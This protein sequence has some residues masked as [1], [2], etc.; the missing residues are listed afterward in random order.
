[1]FFPVIRY[2]YESWTTKKAEHQRTD[3]CELW[4]WRRIFL[5]NWCKEPTHWK[6]PWCL[7]KLRARGEGGDTGWEVGWHHWLNGHK[8]EQSLGDGEGQGSLSC[9]SPCMHAK[10][11]QLCL[12][13]CN[14]MD[15]NP[16][17]PWNSPGK[18]TGVGCLALFHVV[19][20]SQTWLSDW[21]TTTIQKGMWARELQKEGESEMRPTYL[22]NAAQQH[23]KESLGQRPPKAAVVR[24][25]YS[26]SFYLICG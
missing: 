21:T 2:R 3:V 14:P 25:L 9:Y 8:F 24:S 1:M 16:P 18:N 19:A 11:L 15:R 10:S 23:C 12:T 22:G 13:L 6:R 20:K 4:C 7:E 5:A 26:H 17:G